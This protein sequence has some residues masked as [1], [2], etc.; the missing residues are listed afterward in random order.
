MMNTTTH[1]V[2]ENEED[3]GL[4]GG[5]RSRDHQQHC[6]EEEEE[7]ADMDGCRH[8]CSQLVANSTE[9]PLTTRSHLEGGAYVLV[10]LLEPAAAPTSQKLQIYTFLYFTRY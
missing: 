7:E 5:Q 6:Q 9:T 3:V 1:V 10:N 4:P 8:V 2:C